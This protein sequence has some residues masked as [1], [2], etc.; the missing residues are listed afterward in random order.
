MSTPEDRLGSIGGLFDQP[1]P[2]AAQRRTRAPKVAAPES[3]GDITHLFDSPAAPESSAPARRAPAPAGAIPPA[4]PAHP[5]G[6]FDSLTE[7]RWSLGRADEVK[8]WFRQSFGRDLPVTAAGQS[9]THTGMGLDHSDALDVG[10]NPTSDEGKALL[11]YLR[12]N[13][14]PFL[15]YDRAVP[16]A[17]TAAHIHIGF[18]SHRG[19][20][21]EAAR[22]GSIDGLFDAPDSGIEHLF[23]SDGEEAGDV[24]TVNASMAAPSPKLPPLRQRQ[25]FDPTTAEGRQGRDERARLERAPG[26][27]LEVDA[28][29]PPQ[30]RLDDASAGGEMVRGAYVRALVARGVPEAEAVKLVGSDYSLR[31]GSGKVVAPAG[32]IS[33]DNLDASKRTMRVRLDSSHVSKLLDSYKSGRGT[34]GRAADYLTDSERSAGER[35]MDAAGVAGRAA[36]TGYTYVATTPQGV[37]A[38]VAYDK[39]GK[40]A[41]KALDAGD[42]Y[43]WAKAMGYGD[44]TAQMFAAMTYEGIE[45]PAMNPGGELLAR[46]PLLRNNPRWQ[47]GARAFG[48]AILKPSNLVP[49]PTVG[50]LLQAGKL[51]RAVEEGGE[52]AM[53][54]GRLVGAVDRGMVEHAPLGIESAVRSA[55][56]AAEG[57]ADDALEVVLRGDDGAHH[58]VNVQTGDSVNLETGAASTARDSLTTDSAAHPDV[59]R[60]KGRDIVRVEMGDGTVQGFYRSTGNNSKRA[61]EWFPFD[62]LEESPSSEM[63]RGWFQKDR[64]AEG[65]AE[66][67]SHPLHRYGS[68]E[69]REHGELLRASEVPAGREVS[70]PEEVNAWLRGEET[71]GASGADSLTADSVS[72]LEGLGFKVERVDAPNR[73]AS[74]EASQVWKLTDPDGRVNFMRDD[75]ELN[76]FTDYLAS[77]RPAPGSASSGDMA[78]DAARTISTAPA[79]A[80]G[81]GIF[82]QLEALKAGRRP[83]VRISAEDLAADGSRLAVPPG[84]RSFP[85]FNGGRVVYDPAQV[86]REG[87]VEHW[88]AGTLDD[89]VSGRARTEAPPVEPESAAPGALDDVALL[90]DARANAER[91]RRAAEAE[92][93]PRRRA[94]YEGTARE[95]EADVVR[96]ESGVAPEAP[97]VRQMRARKAI[98]S[99]TRG[100]GSTLDA[101]KSN[102]YSA[103]A[104]AGL[105]QALLPLTF[106]TRA[107]LKGLAEGAPSMFAKNHE[108]F[109]KGMRANPL[110][111]E[112]NDVGLALAS[113]NPT[114]RPEYFPSRAASR[115]PWVG[116]SERVMEAQLDAVRLNVYERLTKELRADG[117][118]P[119]TAPEEF[120]DVARIVNIS[121]GQGELGRFMAPASPVLNKVLGSPKLL[122]SRFQVLNPLEYARLSPRARRIALRKAG[123][124]AAAFTGLLGAAA[125]TADEVGL[126]PRKAN[127]GQAR[128][129]STSYD[130]TG[131]MANKL[132][133]VVNLVGSVGRTAKVATSGGSIAYEETPVGVT[134]HFIRSQLSPA[135]SLVA[136][137]VSGETYDGK[138]FTWTEGTAR[139]LAPLFA[140]DVYDGYVT[141][142]GVGAVKALPAFLGVGVRS[143]DEERV[144]G[145]WERA[146]NRPVA[147][148]L[149]EPAQKELQRLGVNLRKLKADVVQP[150]YK[151]EGVDGEKLTPLRKEAD[152][153]LADIS[154]DDTAHDLAEEISAA[155]E[156]AITSP[157]YKSF[158]TDSDRAEYLKQVVRNARA[159]V[160]SGVRLKA[161]AHQLD[162]LQRIEDY[163]HE[164]EHRGPGLKPGETLKL[165]E[166]Q[167]GPV[168]QSAPRED[169]RRAVSLADA[170]AEPTFR[171]FPEG[172]GDSRIPREAMP[173]IKAA[174]RGAMVQFL[175]ARGISHSQEMVPAGSLR[176]SQAEYSPEKVKRAQGYD[177]PERSIL[178]SEDDHVADGHH[179]WLSKLAGENPD[180]LIPVIRLHAPINRLLLEM[181]RFPSSGVDD[182]SA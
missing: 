59:I 1:R 106:E 149:T 146:N 179:Q 117:L 153:A 48:S 159:R 2:A 67:P 154:A 40:P 131:G 50:E 99:L 47:A 145:Q 28:P 116:P 108:A 170:G 98:D 24:V 20:A 152:G 35:V 53:R 13:R 72:R 132:R 122:K 171:E 172:M 85:D 77:W 64:F 178:I 104:S 173:Q 97:H 46:V 124:T 34:L 123:R 103:D 144:R 90:D 57:L 164:L 75:G 54:L 26:A 95:Y 63:G 17:A 155:V 62:G 161:R 49:L 14:V 121:T 55:S 114:A 84:M 107:T 31:D 176:P 16:G 165:G 37:A 12:T 142:G 163:Q 157:D 22:L 78:T 143:F 177:G 9:A 79:D 76:E 141:G 80:S 174:H 68:E 60:Y 130:L 44:V 41:L 127:F 11:G 138:D 88:D 36:K 66:D 105:R 4:T 51:G 8:G 42:T 15:A 113:L 29:L 120:R 65:G 110:A 136:D 129:G 93:D 33:A 3:A 83:V 6:A 134:S 151:V 148:E 7:G 89:L 43:V 71:S 30:D 21:G 58:L 32:A 96:M 38:G 158:A 69:M 139:R 102:L 133:F 162:E 56:G 175:K 86:S 147:V 135:A 126:D 125:L 25:T 168:S 73:T 160:Y 111:Q 137:A 109:V 70:T 166:E 81:A 150:G 82:E 27:F 92:T 94:V 10:V 101:L 39:L 180:R 87:V 19:A 115:L 45:N 18:P 140:Q 61:G 74:G 169:I 112:A 23:D 181:A 91:F 118:T 182:A 167:P 5:H 156:E 100:A 128:W 52:L 119:A